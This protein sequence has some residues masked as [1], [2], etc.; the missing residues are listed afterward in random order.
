VTGEDVGKKR[1]DEEM[2]PTGREPLVI[3]K[4]PAVSQKDFGEDFFPKPVVGE[5]AMGRN[6][7]G[8]TSDLIKTARQ[9][10]PGGTHLGS[11]AD[12]VKARPSVGKRGW[13]ACI[14]TG[15]RG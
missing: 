9:R 11:Q 10:M 2:D 5:L 12:T 1:G 14:C 7:V 4:V 3:Q 15:T 6:R 13:E 8:P